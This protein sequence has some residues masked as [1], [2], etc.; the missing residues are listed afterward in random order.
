MNCVLVN[1]QDCDKFS[2]KRANVPNVYPVSRSYSDLLDFLDYFY[3]CPNCDI[4]AL[5]AIM[6]IKHANSLQQ[7]MLCILGSLK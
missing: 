5:M 3:V 4:K 1:I 7:Y 6:V 2:S